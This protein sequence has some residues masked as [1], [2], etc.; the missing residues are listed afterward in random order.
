MANIKALVKYVKDNAEYL[1]HNNVLFNIYEGDLNK[2]VERD[3]Q[4]QLSPKAYNLAKFRIAPINILRRI[5]DKLS[6]I[7]AKSPRRI[8]LVNGEPSEKDQVLLDWYIQ[9]MQC[10]VYWNIA[11]ELFNLSKT[12]SVEPFVD[13]GLP[14]MR[15]IP[16]DRFMYYSD[17]MNDP[18]KP[19]AWIKAM[20]SIY[21][22]K[23]QKQKAIFYI[24]TDEEFIPVTEDGVV[25]TDVLAKLENPNA[26]NPYGKIPSVYVNKSFHSIT[27]PI[28]S[29]VLAMTKLIPVLL[30]DLNYA[31]M[32]Q[33]F[34]IIYG[35]DV[36]QENLVMAPNVFWNLKSD[37]TS[38]KKPEVGT[39]KPEVDI[40]QV[41]EF[42]KAQLIL[43]LNSKNI[44]PGSVG[45]L[46]AENM[47]SGIAKIVDEMDTFEDRQKQ[48][49]FFQKAEYDFWALI[50][51]NMH[52]Y[53]RSQKMIDT[54]LDFSPNVEIKV[55]FPEQ[56][57]MSDR[58]KLIDDAIK[59]LDKALT[60]KE[61]A[62]KMINPDM[63]SAQV[64]ALLEEIQE[65]TT[66][67]IP[68]VT[69]VPDEPTQ[70]EAQIQ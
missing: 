8:A 1:K 6:K 17:D 37:K 9:H 53:W 14:R 13:K 21:D 59:E 60:T 29:D 49:Q 38:D 5:V 50:S 3:L 62:I 28:D 23:E 15:A 57:P 26:Q 27:P 24:Y 66:I 46:S 2:Y 10:D 34:S 4:E 64:E 18:T 33:A 67:E 36:D 70:E 58:S 68:E 41:M 7:Y 47:A 35:I 31:V 54:N 55:E 42:I 32:M 30:S 44:R 25:L 63:D 20:G 16:N 39:I 11:N 12:V 48:V 56:L 61:R 19:T 22:D 65:E 69:E 40:T 51:Q 43:W 45:D 52:P